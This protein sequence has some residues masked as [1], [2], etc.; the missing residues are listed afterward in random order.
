MKDQPVE[1]RLAAWAGLGALGLLQADEREA[2]RVLYFGRAAGSDAALA[3]TQDENGNHFSDA[4]VQGCPNA[5]RVTGY[6]LEPSA[7]G[8]TS[9]REPW[10]SLLSRLSQGCDNP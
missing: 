3:I 6:V 7:E 4:W 1:L 9:P 5:V 8:R 2:E 10:E